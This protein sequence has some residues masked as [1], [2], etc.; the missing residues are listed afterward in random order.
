MKPP[1]IVSVRAFVVKTKDA[2]GDYYA[3]ES[4]HWLTEIESAS[5]MSRYS[6]FRTPHTK[7]GADVLGSVLVEIELSSGIIGIATGVGGELACFIVEKHFSRFLIGADPRDLSRLWDQMY[8]ASLPYGRKG[9]AICAIGIVD[10]ALWDALGKMRGEP[11]Y[12]LIGGETKKEIPAYCTGPKPATYKRQGFMGAKVTLRFAPADGV[13]G[14]RANVSQLA[15]LREEVGPQYPL[16]I[17]CFMS[18]DVQYAGELARQI[19]N[20]GFYWIEEALHPEDFLGYREL[21]TAAPWIRWVTG[22][23][24]YTRFGFREL[25]RDRLVDVIQPDLMYVGGLT[26]ALRVA[27]LA[28][29]FDVALVPHCGGVYSYHFAMSQPDISFVE[30]LNTSADGESITPVLGTMFSGEPVPQA[31]KITLSDSPGWGLELNRDKLEL[32]RPSFLS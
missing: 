18:L 19:K 6:K 5:P 7:W 15:S 24:E 2:G 22:E 27:A 12:K 30:F 17:D 32:H 16:M 25:I 31:G 11:V 13:D 14:L 8:R 1:K 20:L 29:T 28:S 21:K 10:L 26:E 4:G 3:R 9:I 23:H